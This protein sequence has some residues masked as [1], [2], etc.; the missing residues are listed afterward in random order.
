MA[1]TR[2]YQFDTGTV[3][4]EADIEGEFDQIYGS[5]L[6][7]I[8]PLTGN[9]AF[10]GN[11]A[12]GLS[13]GTVSGPSVQFTGD[14]NT[15]FYSSAAD[16]V[17]IA[18]GG[19]RAASFG[20]SFLLSAVPEDARTNTVDVAGEI[21]S[22]TSGVPAAS[23]GVGLLFS[24]ESG[25]ENPSEF[26]RIDFVASDITAASEDTYLSVLLR[27]AGAALDEK[28]RFSA[29]S[30]AG[31]A[32]LFTHANT[33][34]RTYTLPDTNSTL[35][36]VMLLFGGAADDAIAAGQTRYTGPGDATTLEGAENNTL[37]VPVPAGTLRNFRVKQASASG[38]GQTITHTVRVDAADTGLS[39]A[40][41]GATATTGT[42][43]DSVTVTAGQL[44]TVSHVASAG[45]TSTR[46]AWSCEL[47]I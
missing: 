23:I 14:T 5:S 4:A 20:A 8:S 3:L 34:D 41:S 22:T 9:L 47:V 30:G 11:L 40:I 6:S 39:I 46:F 31:F 27:A 10:G 32:A 45:A 37:N 7:L 19:V 43:T 29:T 13:L 16:T 17:D 24:A 36:A 42:D 35:G 38:A 44:I 26:G 12:T 2:L 28:Y 25:D 15:G 18:T 21:R 1:L 33:A